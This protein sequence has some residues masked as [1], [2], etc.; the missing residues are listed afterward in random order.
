MRQGQLP[1]PVR[2]SRRCTQVAPPQPQK[3]AESSALLAIS[4]TNGPES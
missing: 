3:T 1:N 4:H 2:I